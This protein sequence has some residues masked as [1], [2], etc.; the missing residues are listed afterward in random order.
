MPPST[1]KLV[2]S[3][4]PNSL[5]KLF[6]STCPFLFFCRV[7]ISIFFCLTCCQEE[8]TLSVVTTTVLAVFWF[9]NT[10]RSNGKSPRLAKTIRKG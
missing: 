6:K 8:S 9:S 5:S 1:N 10:L 4:L 3:R 7:I 2:I